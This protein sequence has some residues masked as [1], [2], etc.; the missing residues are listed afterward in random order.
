MEKRTQL[1]EFL[2]YKTLNLKF[3]LMNES[4][5]EMILEDSESKE[6]VKNVCAKMPIALVNRLEET[7]NFLECSKRQFIEYAIIDAIE[8]AR[9]IVDKLDVAEYL[10]ES[11]FK[12]KEQEK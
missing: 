5:R 8:K 3:S 7:V 12:E 10:T 11:C 6:T 9:L 2:E 4:L 1:A